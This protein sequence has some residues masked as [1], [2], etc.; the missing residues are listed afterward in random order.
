M[1]GNTGDKRY[2][3]LHRGNRVFGLLR[4]I[5]EIDFP[6]EELNIVEGKPRRRS[7]RGLRSRWFLGELFYQ[8]GEVVGAVFVADQVDVRFDQ[9]DLLQDRRPA[10]QRSLLQIRVELLKGERGCRSLALLHDK[11]TN[12][13]G[14]RQRINADLL[15][16]D[17]PVHF[18]RKLRSDLVFQKRPTNQHH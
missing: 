13:E 12:S 9:L 3:D 7:W 4:P 11:A 15:D 5:V 2:T 10:K 6:V 16:R 1:R 17:G 14:H 8:V 18:G